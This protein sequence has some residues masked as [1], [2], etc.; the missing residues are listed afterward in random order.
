MFIPPRLS[1]EPD[2]V[3]LEDI[4]LRRLKVTGNSETYLA[5]QVRWAV[6]LTNFNRIAILLRDFRTKRPNTKF[7]GNVCRSS[8]TDICGQI[9]QTY[10]WTWGS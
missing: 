4:A 7:H 2:I 8:R 9:Q 5:F 1:Q 10:G 3:L 6:F